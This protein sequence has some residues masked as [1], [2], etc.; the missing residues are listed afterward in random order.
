MRQSQ[1]SMPRKAAFRKSQPGEPGSRTPSG[2]AD[3]RPVGSDD[4]P[5]ANYLDVG[6][7]NQKLRT[8]DTLMN[9]AA[10][11]ILNGLTVT[12][13]DV[14]DAAGVSRTTAYRY[15]PTSDM[16]SAQATLF[17][18]GRIETRHLDEIARGPGSPEEKLDA[19]IV[20]SDLMTSVH[21]A[22]YRSVLRFSVEAG[23][24]TEYG[25]PRRPT[26][27]RDWLEAALA[28]VRKELGPPRFNRLI[29]VLSLLC[30]IESFVVLHDI[31]SMRSD[32]AREAKRWAGTELL[33]SALTENVTE[34]KR[35]RGTGIGPSR[36]GT[37]HRPGSLVNRT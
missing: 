5:A 19:V 34:A 23:G 36:S 20:A 11:R 29:G 26:F 24:K 10:E 4:S 35:A 30:G 14:A 18:A 17:V 6:R 12:V 25:A 9:V 3:D 33:R 32:E 7:V 27:R 15:F 16:L 31:C 21:E 37:R 2:D 28:D 22:A 8:R 1:P 13:T